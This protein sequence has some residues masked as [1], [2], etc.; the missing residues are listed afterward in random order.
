MV[1]A[2]YVTSKA[3]ELRTITRLGGAQGNTMDLSAILYACTVDFSEPHS[4]PSLAC[5]VADTERMREI[6]AATRNLQALA[7]NATT[8]HALALL[9]LAR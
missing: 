7:R 6:S 5:M 9:A 1:R 8:S 2:Q 4:C 3:I